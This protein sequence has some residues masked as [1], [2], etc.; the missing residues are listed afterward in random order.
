MTD[1]S[2]ERYVIRGANATLRP[3]R[4]DDLA[5]LH[6]LWTHPDVRRYV[7][8]DE[9]IPRSRAEAAVR[10]AIDAFESHGFGL[11]LAEG[12]DGALLGFC[13]LRHLDDGP[14]VEVIYGVAPSEWG[15][16]LATEMAEAML[17][18]GFGTVGLPRLVGIADAP[19]AASRRV[20]EKAGMSFDRYTTDEGRKEARYSVR[21]QDLRPTRPAKS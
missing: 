9:E 1:G 8:D 10:E 4:R 20:L 16:G 19:N 18:Y 11:W 21:P 2:G 5:P 3:V 6:R 7:W 12:E 15:R 17:R 13:G 14:D